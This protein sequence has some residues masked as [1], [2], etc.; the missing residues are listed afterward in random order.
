[1]NDK[2]IA[3]LVA[4]VMVAPICAACILGPVFMGSIVAGAWGWLGGLG[5]AA[6]TGLA[7]TAGVLVYGLI[8]WKNAKAATG[9]SPPVYT[10]RP[11]D[12]GTQ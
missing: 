1:M 4:A 5:L 12:R 2:L 8:R 9:G 6:A 7:V 10:S 11:M 3:G